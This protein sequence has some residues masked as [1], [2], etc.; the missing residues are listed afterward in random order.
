MS[1]KT[2]GED[3]R[4]SL[5]RRMALTFAITSSSIVFL[6]GLWSSYFVFDALRDDTRDFME[7][8][9]GELAL[10]ISRTGRTTAD[11]VACIEAVLEV[12]EHP[13]LAFRVR[14]EKGDVVYEG[15]SRRLL[16]LKK[17]VREDASWSTAFF[18]RRIAH[19]VRELDEPP[20]RIALITDTDDALDEV[21]DYFR[22]ALLIFLVT[23]ALAGLAGWYT[24]H[25]GL[26]GLRAVT[27]QARGMAST[28][29]I[30][31]IRVDG[32]P[33]EVREAGAALNALLE[34]I[35]RGMDDL[36]TF[37]AGLAHELRSPL[38]NLIGE[39]EVALLSDREPREYQDVLRSNLDDLQD[40][41][42]AVDNLVAWCRAGDPD[43]RELRTESFDLAR[44]VEFRLVT[45]RRAAERAGVGFSF[46]TD[47]KTLL[48]ADR[49]DC[50]RVVK[51][52]VG[53]AIR[54]VPAGGAVALRITGRNGEVR[55]EVE[56]DGPGVPPELAERI[57]QP[58]VSGPPL[59]GRRAGYGLGLA[60][61]R[62]IVE[63]HGGTLSHENRPEGG[64]RFTA[65]IRDVSA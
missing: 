21:V 37:T 9:L 45:T 10:E 50:L 16:G 58:F 52:L 55:I 7:H 44:E 49:E 14:D 61:C 18:T 40:L 13:D 54:H 56:D 42:E 8:E 63:A 30:A 34:R 39:T 25:R 2:A 17:R 46:E 62:T 4:W 36:R 27:A 15:G 28:A 6:Y 65:V 48:R 1:S 41:S 3:R 47:G 33:D 12:E 59:D 19:D 51:N 11:V 24:A 22:A 53:N 5:T 60:I 43:R 20:V 31:T 64:A 57:Y 23:V 35:Q 32:A 29:G 26:Q 38:Q